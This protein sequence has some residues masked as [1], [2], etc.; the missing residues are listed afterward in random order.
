MARL[1]AQACALA[2]PWRAQHVRPHLQAFVELQ[3]AHQQ[4]EELGAEVSALPPCRSCL[5]VTVRP[6]STCSVLCMH[7]LKVCRLLHC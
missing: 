6:V 7:P 4:R 1:C 5:G 3:E 2:R